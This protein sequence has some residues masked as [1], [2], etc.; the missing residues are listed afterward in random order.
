MMEEISEKTENRIETAYN[1]YTNE[2]RENEIPNITQKSGGQLYLR[3]YYNRA[4]SEAMA[5]RIANREEKTKEEMVS[6]IGLPENYKR[7]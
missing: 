5:D 7:E 2:L 1:F 6:R 4:I 3:E